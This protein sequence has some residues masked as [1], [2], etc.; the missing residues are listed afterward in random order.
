MKPL[1]LLLTAHVL[2]AFASC[3]A[4]MKN[5]RTVTVHVN[6][7][8]E[9]CERTIEKVAYVKGEAEADWDVDAKTA[10]ISYDSTRT[11]LDAVLKRI[12]H[13][14]YDSEQYLAPD[15]AYAA[16][17]GCC[18]YQ[19]TDKHVAV[20]TVTEEHAHHGTAH[21]HGSVVATTDTIEVPPPVN[22]KTDQFNA[23]FTAYFALKD[24]LVASDATTAAV[25]GG[26][27]AAAVKAVQMERMGPD[28]HG[29]WMQMMEPLAIVGE[30]IASKTDIDVQRKAFTELTAPLL[31]LVKVAPRAEPVYYDH[32][33]MYEGG[34]YW[35]SQEKPIKN[36]FYG[37]MMLTCGSVKETLQ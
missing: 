36:P 28:L 27:F 33:P 8:C 24:A 19:R 6:G 3:S 32:C 15:A 1:N 37:S 13:A 2:F 22:P 4:Q 18:Q 35:L 9:M 21:E 12:A 26:A 17:P 20:G 31:A 25:H 30:G 7:D 5:A 34:A 11:T 14:G 23:L 10:R 16:L 29:T